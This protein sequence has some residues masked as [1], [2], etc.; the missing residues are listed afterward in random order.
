M[1]SLTNCWFCYSLILVDDTV[2]EPC[3]VCKVLPKEHRPDTS[4]RADTMIAGAA[5]TTTEAESNVEV[6]PAL[7]QTLVQQ[8]ASSSAPWVATNVASAAPG[9]AAATNVEVA[10]SPNVANDAEDIFTHA[11]NDATRLRKASTRW[12]WV[13]ETGQ[14][15]I[16]P[17][18]HVSCVIGRDPEATLG[19][20]AVKI[21]DK[22]RTVS[23]SHA[24]L[25]Y[26]ATQ[27]QW[28]VADLA[29]SNGTVV[30]VNGQEVDV[31]AN[32]A[33]WVP[34]YFKLGDMACRITRMQ[35]PSRP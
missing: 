35:V 33:E 27:A 15:D 31:A 2:T 8:Q 9:A 28:H 18:P 12:A 1:K 23:K 14:G 19:E 24:R 11:E 5:I 3:P 10:H 16:I 32:T 17:L 13:V 25:T 6:Q 4:P 30:L 34:Q 21:H 7:D 26:D 29:S 20:A 22:T